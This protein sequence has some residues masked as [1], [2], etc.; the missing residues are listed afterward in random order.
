VPLLW[1][2]KTL[3][4]LLVIILWLIL[5]GALLQRDFFVKKLDLHEAR[6]IKQ[7]QETEFLGIHFQNQRIGY[8]KNRL[9]AAADG[10]GY[11][12]LED[13]VLRLNI[14]G[15]I[16]PIRMHLEAG[17]TESLL[18][19]HF[20]FQLFSPFYQVDAQGLVAGGEID[21][22]IRTGKETIQDTVQLANQ[23]F[24]P[25]N[26]RGYLLGTDLKPGDK[27]KI[28][29]FDPIS[30]TGKDTIVEYKGIDKV[31]IEGRIYTLHHF[32]ESFA[33]VRIST[34]L[35]NTGKVVKEE[36]P[37]GF[38]FISEPEFKATDI[39]AKG[40]ELLRRVAV[41]LTGTMPK[42]TGATQMRYILTLPEGVEFSLD[43]DRQH[44]TG[45]LLSVT[46]E[47]LADFDAGPCQGRPAEL[48]STPY[49][50]AKNRMITELAATV[51]RDAGSAMA[52]VRRL[53]TWVHDN[54]E[55]RPVLGIP[56]ALTTLQTRRGDCNEHAALFTA[57]ARSVGIP[58]RVAAGVTLYQGAFYY[59]AWNEVC[60]GENWL[61]LDT[62]RNQLPADLTHIKF[63]D[64]GINDMV[65][66]GSLINNLQIAAVAEK[67][68]AQ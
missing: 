56:D 42:L 2:R 14:L 63:V 29:Y 45:N 18:L 30:L 5:F 46:L 1:N 15:E 64:G 51:T 26:H 4:R 50:Q 49:I 6:I 48:A 13:A 40:D 38:V 7:A 62:T 11:T 28:P 37:A 65:K 22:T 36:S 47:N 32:T 9:S 41:P 27:L 23:P 52:K 19:Q 53:A 25:T 60:L 59:H 21:L 31:L 35:D 44:L 67:G 55:K 58:T 54:L 3:F 68:D 8:V 39:V 66:I 17:L 33:G 43:K 24:L 12:L 16:H 20:T 57:L 10:N 61:S 34:W